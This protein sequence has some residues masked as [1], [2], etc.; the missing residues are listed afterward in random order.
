LIKAATAWDKA[1]EDRI[2]LMVQLD[3]AQKDGGDVNTA[4]RMLDLHDEQ[5]EALQN[6]IYDAREALWGTRPDVDEPQDSEDES[7]D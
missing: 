7:D 6:Q 5:I 1:V 4:Q 2:P 3:K